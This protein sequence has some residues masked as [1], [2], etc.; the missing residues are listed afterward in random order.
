MS[1]QQRAAGGN[2]SSRIKN[3]LFSLD[4]DHLVNGFATA[5]PVNR[6]R[7]DRQPKKEGGNES[8]PLFF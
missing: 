5:D 2:F 6:L 1:A 3:H 7:D 4:V 8:Y